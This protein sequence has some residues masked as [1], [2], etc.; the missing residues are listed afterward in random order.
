[1]FLS[2]KK[3]KET[4]DD[5]EPKRRVSS[6]IGTALSSTIIPGLGQLAKG[7]PGKAA[8]FFFGIMIGSPIVGVLAK[9]WRPAGSIAGIGVLGVHIW[10]IVDAARGEVKTKQD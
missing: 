1:M 7:E 10:N 2:F 9:A 5:T 3:K 4:L 6:R 8:A